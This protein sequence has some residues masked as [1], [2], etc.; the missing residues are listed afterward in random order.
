[1]TR[2]PFLRPKRLIILLAAILVA[3]TSGNAPEYLS[4]FPGGTWSRADSPEAA[5]LSH[6]GLEAVR[7][8]ADSIGTT[9]L[10]MVKHGK[11]ALEYGDIT[12]LSYIASARKSV[13]AML[14]GRYV[15]DG[16]IDMDKTLA[17]LN[18]DD[19]G[20][21]TDAER[22]ATICDL[23]G[24]RSGVYHPAS[25]SG[26]NLADAPPR[27]SQTHGSYFLYSNWDFNALGAIFEQETGVNIYDAL[28]TN[29]AI[30]LGM[31]DFDREAQR[32]SGNLERSR[33]PAYHMWFSTRDMARIGY[34]M[35]RSGRW[36]GEQLVPEEW[37]KKITSPLT[38][39]EEMNPARYRSGR[40]GY[41][42]LWWVFDGPEAIGVF[43]GGYTGIGAGGQYITVLPELDL[44]VA[45]KTNRGRTRDSVSRGEYLM[46]LDLIVGA[47]TSK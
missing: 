23:I 15:E 29:L 31:Q 10:V 37:V 38:P 7:A 30:P 47:H 32:K 42:Y 39:F 26:D 13:L 35:L 27:G 18:I 33:F 5:G 2:L 46:L 8:H 6:A 3:C 14:F 19:I 4:T 20:G 43:E 16:T 36:N 44:V 41:G 24:A 17:E 11:I 1:M 22:E 28:Q 40:F 12:E 9:G 34:L 45:H 21:L 25:N